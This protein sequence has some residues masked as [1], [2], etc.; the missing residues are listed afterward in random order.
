MHSLRGSIPT[1]DARAT[2]ARFLLA[3]LQHSGTTSPI[4][5]RRPQAPRVNLQYSAW[6]H[7]LHLRRQ[8][9]PAYAP[10]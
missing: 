6:R 9:A 2:A 7:R 3:E 8:A 5:R 1:T 10:A 4:G